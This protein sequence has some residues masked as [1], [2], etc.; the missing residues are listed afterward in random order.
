MCQPR[1]Q[2]EDALGSK[3]GY[4]WQI[5]GSGGQKALNTN[6]TINSYFSVPILQ[7]KIW[8]LCHWRF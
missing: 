5:L 6:N 2:S 8:Y 4:V 7:E 3:L 1:P